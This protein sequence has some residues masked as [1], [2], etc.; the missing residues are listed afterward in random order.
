MHVKK[1]HMTTLDRNLFENNL[2]L[3]VITN[4][5]IR[6]NINEQYMNITI[7][8]MAIKYRFISRVAVTGA[9]E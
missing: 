1:L 6:Q 2:S 4:H 5:I 3:L 8:S 7:Y 9:G